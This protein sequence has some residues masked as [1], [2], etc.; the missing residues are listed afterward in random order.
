MFSIQMPPKSFQI[1][2]IKDALCNAEL[3]WH[4]IKV[5]AFAVRDPFSIHKPMAVTQGQSRG[6]FFPLPVVFVLRTEFI[7]LVD[8]PSS[9][10]SPRFI[11]IDTAKRVEQGHSCMTGAHLDASMVRVIKFGSLAPRFVFTLKNL[12]QTL[13]GGTKCSEKWRWKLQ[14]QY[15]YS[16]SINE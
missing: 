10:L 7:P 4:Q 8:T 13:Q 1:P 12:V 2:A 9:F 16:R 14:R 3:A 15:V 11:I 6:S 5:W